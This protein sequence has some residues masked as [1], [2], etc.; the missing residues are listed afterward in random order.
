MNSTSD[1]MQTGD[2][3]TP[4]LPDEGESVLVLAPAM[5]SRVDEC[6]VDISCREAPVD[7]DLLAVAL[8][9]SVDDVLDRWNRHAGAT[10][11]RTAVVT[12]G[13]SVRGAAAASQPGAS[14]LGS[15]VSLTSVTDPGDLTGLGIKISQC[16]SNWEG[17]HNDLMLCFDS[18]TTLLQF[19]ELRQVFQ[20]VHVLTQRVESAG[21]RA[22]FHMNQYAHDDQTVATVRSLFDHVYELDADGSWRRR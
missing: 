2:A 20:F 21:A 5:D 11:G 8:D 12:A 19:A 1:E 14:M 22:H 3:D 18:L 10:P 4:P 9:G 6:C 7:V 17:S 16:L 13:E 15:D